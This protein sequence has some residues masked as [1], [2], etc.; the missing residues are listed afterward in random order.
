[1]VSVGLATQ[2]GYSLMSSCICDVV[3]WM[4][5]NHLQLNTSKSEVLWFSSVRRQHLI[6]DTP[7]IA[8]VDAVLPARS[9][10]NLGIYIDSDV[11]MR[12]HILHRAASVLCVRSVVFVGQS[13]NMFFCPLLSPRCLPDMV[14]HRLICQLIFA[15]RMLTPVGDFDPHRRQRCSFH[16][17]D[18]QQLVTEL[19]QLPLHALGTVYHPVSL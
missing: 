17:R 15:S 18:S 6:P 11:S 5:S 14:W 2:P 9:V 16:A 19:S 8:G 3:S 12:I 1:M 7:L 13:A 4:Q 10:R